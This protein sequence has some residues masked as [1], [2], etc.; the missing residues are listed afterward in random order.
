MCFPKPKVVQMPA[1]ENEDANK[2]AAAARIQAEDAKR[3]EI[4]KK[5]N[6]KREDITAAIDAKTSKGSGSGGKGRRSL[7]SSAGGGQG[8]LNRFG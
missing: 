6:T 2:A 7:Y 1:A 8:Y 3:R 4:E 5:A